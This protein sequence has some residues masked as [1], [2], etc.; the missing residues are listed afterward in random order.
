MMVVEPTTEFCCDD[1]VSFKDS[2][3]TITSEEHPSIPI[4]NPI[5]SSVK[6]M[7]GTCV[8]H[9][10]EATMVV[11][12]QKETEYS[13]DVSTTNLPLIQA[14]LSTYD[15][16]RQRKL[17]SMI[18][19]VGL[20]LKW[21]ERDSLHQLLLEKNQVFAVEEGEHGSTD[22]IQMTVDTGDAT[23]IKQTLRR[24]PF[25]CKTRRR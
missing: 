8:G 17:T 20:T 24:T 19:E 25:C 9:A 3:V 5:G 13:E 15:S 11:V 2:F 10:V 22:V 23:P 7:E 16:V 12:D 1:K 14:I 6:L 21:K 18:A 4:S